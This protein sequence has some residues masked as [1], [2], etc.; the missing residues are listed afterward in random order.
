MPRLP[1]PIVVVAAL[2]IAMPFAAHAAGPL[3]VTS[4]VMVESKVRA[5]DGTTRVVLAPARRVVPGDRVVLTLAYRNTGAVP[6]SNIAFDNPVPKGLAYRSPAAGSAAPDL[7]VDGRSYG[8]LSTLRVPT[9][10][11][12][13][14]AATP[15]D[16]T[17]VR[18]RLDRPL[19]A[20][21]K[22]QF[23]FQAVLK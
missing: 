17:H 18:W 6:L 1:S 13:W 11:G 2:A 7:S 21:A 5:A 15:D 14:R 8:P 23:A 12:G 16:V 9:A 19:T 20:G 22:G 10:G 3:V 4:G